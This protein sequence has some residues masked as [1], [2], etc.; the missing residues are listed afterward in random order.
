MIPFQ[1]FFL[2]GLV[3]ASLSSRPAAAQTTPPPAPSVALASAPSAYHSLFWGLFQSKDEHGRPVGAQQ[4]RADRMRVQTQIR[5]QMQTVRS[6][7][8]AGLQPD[9]TYQV[10]S[11]LGGAVQWTEKIPKSLPASTR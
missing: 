2:T 3:A 6:Q 5:S 11:I 8:Q 10:R 4:V 9:S 7:M 1:L